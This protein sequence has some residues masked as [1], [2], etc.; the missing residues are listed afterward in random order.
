MKDL[1]VRRVYTKQGINIAVDI[2][3]VKKTVS[4]VEK[5]GGNKKWIFAERSLEYMNGWIL[6]LRAMEYAVTEAKKELEAIKEQEHED[7]VNM[8]IELDKS[9][10]KG[11]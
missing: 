11:K 8:Y 4:L 3:Y 7:F 6:I 1:F 10:K 5:N 2:D 9:L